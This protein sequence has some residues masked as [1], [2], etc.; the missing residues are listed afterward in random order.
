MQIWK[1]HFPPQSSS[2]LCTKLRT[3]QTPHSGARASTC[4]LLPL[5]PPFTAL[6]SASCDCPCSSQRSPW[7]FICGLWNILVLLL[8][9]SSPLLPVPLP[10]HSFWFELQQ[11]FLSF[12]DWFRSPFLHASTASLPSFIEL[13]TLLRFAKFVIV[14]SS[15]QLK[16]LTALTSL[17]WRDTWWREILLLKMECF[18][19]I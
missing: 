13:T 7:S 4:S 8:D 10:L 15:L 16:H 14:P 17:V 1:R 19:N 9:P 5:H 18:K 2:C 11:S 12:Q 6:P 3:R